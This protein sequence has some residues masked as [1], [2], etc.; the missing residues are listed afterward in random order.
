MGRSQPGAS[1]PREPE[2]ESAVESTVAAS[3]GAAEESEAVSDD[4]PHQG[5]PEEEASAS[6][7][8]PWSW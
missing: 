1:D 4:P 3:E 7:S 8:S 6:R 2:V 5:E